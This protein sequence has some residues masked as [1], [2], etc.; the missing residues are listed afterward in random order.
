MS[1][2]EPTAVRRHGKDQLTLLYK[3]KPQTLK[4]GQ[5][6][7]AVQPVTRFRH[8]SGDSY[9]SG[10]LEYPENTVFMKPTVKL[11]VLKSVM[12]TKNTNAN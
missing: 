10:V 4:A 3:D 11:L 9:L 7:T 2:V 1:I 8:L 6:L 5:F 12:R